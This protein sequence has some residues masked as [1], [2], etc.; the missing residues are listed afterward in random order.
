MG[1]AFRTVSYSRLSAE[2]SIKLAHLYFF[3]I[4]FQIGLVIGDN[5]RFSFF[6]DF[7]RK[8]FPPGAFF[9]VSAFRLFDLSSVQVFP[10]AP[11]KIWRA[12]RISQIYALQEFLM[13]AC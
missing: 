12:H 6:S 2:D 7:P 4:F 9:G 1:W 5:R 3:T 10:V 13:Q 11:G 8:R